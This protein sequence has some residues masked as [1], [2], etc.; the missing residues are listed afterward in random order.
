MKVQCLVSVGELLDKVSVLQIKKR[1][2]KDKEK[3]LNICLE[4][5]E[6]EKIAQSLKN[7]KK[8]VSEIRKIN[9]LIWLSVGKIW[10]YEKNKSFNKNFI[11]L[12]RDIYILNDKRYALKSKINLYYKSYIKEEKSY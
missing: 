12:A 5:E 9:Y 2:V 3:L 6:L 11:K 1:M 8:W 10:A 7:Y 4:L